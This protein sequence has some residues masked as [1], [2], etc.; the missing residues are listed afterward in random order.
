MYSLTLCHVSVLMN[1]LMDSWNE[2]IKLGIK[3]SDLPR[4]TILSFTIYDTYGPDKCLPVGSTSISVFSRYGSM[5]KGFYD[6]RIKPGVGSDPTGVTT[7]GKSY[8]TD[9]V[10]TL[11]KV[12]ID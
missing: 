10:T 12:S 3:I 11:N 1:I 9:R 4:D 7:C 8:Q 6:L 2:W 5:R